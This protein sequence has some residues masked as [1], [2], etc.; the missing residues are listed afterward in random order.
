[1]TFEIFS[2]YAIRNVYIRV[3]LGLVSGCFEIT[4]TFC[5]FSAISRLSNL[6]G[7][8]RQTSRTI[9]R[10]LQ[11]RQLFENFQYLW[12]VSILCQWC[13]SMVKVK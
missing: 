11:L 10:N 6:F 7:N 4:V 1:M 5:N 3:F 8:T 9:T 2:L 13:W 12:W